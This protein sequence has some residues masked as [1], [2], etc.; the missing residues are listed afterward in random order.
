MYMMFTSQE[1][2]LDDTWYIDSGCSN[3]MTGNK[4]LIKN[5]DTSVQREVRTGD[6]KKLN[7]Q[8]NGEILVKTMHSEKR[9]PNVYFVPRLRHNLLSVEQFLLSG[10]EV[11][12]KDKLY[13]IKDASNTLLG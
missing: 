9:I 6:D 5:I 13:E 7:V 8:G 12:F 3:H 11:Y 4:I 1:T 10:Y 2:N